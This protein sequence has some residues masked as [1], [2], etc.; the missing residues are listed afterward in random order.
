MSIYQ[1]RSHMTEICTVE[2]QGVKGPMII[3][4]NKH[5]HATDAVLEEECGLLT[6]TVRRHEHHSATM[7]RLCRVV[8]NL[9]VNRP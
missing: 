2:Q 3:D 1:F 9:D 7:Y 6:P 8:E 4:C 5:V